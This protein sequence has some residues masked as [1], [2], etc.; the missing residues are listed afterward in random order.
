[1]GT[2]QVCGHKLKY[3]SKRQ[4]LLDPRGCCM[5]V[6]K[7]PCGKRTRTCQKVA[8]ECRHAQ[9]RGVKQSVLEPPP[10]LASENDPV[11]PA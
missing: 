8:M 10:Q 9:G 7:S 11:L 5:T 1:M 2:T 6:D 3:N 4:K